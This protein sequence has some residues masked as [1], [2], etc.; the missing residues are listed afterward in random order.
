MAVFQFACLVDRMVYKT[1]NPMWSLIFWSYLEILNLVFGMFIK[2]HFIIV[3][4]Y[5]V[6]KPPLLLK[7]LNAPSWVRKFW[8]VWREINL[9]CTKLSGSINP[10]SNF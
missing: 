7:N 10:L 1:Q 3:H 4:N 2:L 6:S 9:N 5:E 8:L